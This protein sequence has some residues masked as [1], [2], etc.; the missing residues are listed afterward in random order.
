[1]HFKS[2]SILI[3]S[4]LIYN[5]GFAQS[6]KDTLN[7]V[8]EYISLEE[9]LKNPEKVYRLN[10]SNQNVSIPKEVWSKFTNLEYLSLKNDHL[11]KLPIEI[12]LLKKLKTLD[13]SGNDFKMLPKSFSNLINLEELLLNDEKSFD[14]DK[15][16]KTLKPLANLKVLHLENDS[17]SKLPKNFIE[18]NQLE[19]IYLNNNNF[20]A[21]PTEIKRLNHLKYLDL[22]NNKLKLEDRNT[23]N[24]GFGIKID[25]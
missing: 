1:M 9:A 2:I 15:N 16:I 23:I 8:N 5:I 12:G 7:N 21:V 11:K 14:L 25:F 3:V 22:H 10:L 6:P 24:E 18:L 20:N 19:S 17:L 13:L 4:I